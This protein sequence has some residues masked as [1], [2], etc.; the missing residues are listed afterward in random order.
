MLVFLFAIFDQ[1]HVIRLDGRSLN[2]SLIRPGDFGWF[3][4]LIFGTTIFGNIFCVIS[5]LGK[6]VIINRIWEICFWENGPFKIKIIYVY[7][8]C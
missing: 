2:F 6:L 1:M 7:E 8:W 5:I 3:R 4:F